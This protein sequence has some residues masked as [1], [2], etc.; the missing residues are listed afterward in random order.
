VSRLLRQR[1]HEERVSAAKLRAKIALEVGSAEPHV[2]AARFIDAERLRGL[3][4]VG[5]GTP[6]AVRGSRPGV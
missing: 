3:P 2:N 6:G 5:R 1:H 4:A